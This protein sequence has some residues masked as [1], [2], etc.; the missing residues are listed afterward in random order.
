MS[1]HHV[2]V[3]SIVVCLIA[4]IVYLVVEVFD[5]RIWWNKRRTPK[6]PSWKRKSEVKPRGDTW[7]DDKRDEAE[8]EWRKALEKDD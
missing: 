4:A 5:F 7:P 6:V 8:V 2:E 3:A 1:Y